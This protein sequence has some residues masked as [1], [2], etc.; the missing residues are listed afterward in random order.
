MDRVYDEPQKKIAALAVDLAIAM[1]ES[2]GKY[3]ERY[4]AGI[5][6]FGGPFKVFTIMPFAREFDAVKTALK[7]AFGDQPLKSYLGAPVEFTRADDQRTGTI[8]ASIIESICKADL[9]VADLTGNNPNVLFEYG[10]A[11]A[12]G[13]RII[14]ISRSPADTVTDLRNQKITPYYAKELAANDYSRFSIDLFKAIEELLETYKG[15]DPVESASLED[16]M[17]QCNAVSTGFECI[18]RNEWHRRAK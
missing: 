15:D 7:L 11:L 3:H 17:A 1:A 10:Y 16:P 5:R 2:K 13:K 14:P 8:D 9:L 4:D 12:L 6:N 18:F